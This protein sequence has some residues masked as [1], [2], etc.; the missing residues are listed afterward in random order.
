VL[1]SSDADDEGMLISEV[2]MRERRPGH[3]KIL[4]D[5]Q[6]NGSGYCSVFNTP[7]KV[8]DY[9]DYVPVQVVVLDSS[10]PKMERHQHEK[11]LGEAI[12]GSAGD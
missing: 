12:N 7:Q 1:V 8:I 3:C 10:I 2:A 5:A 4:A 6:W 9:I 11:L